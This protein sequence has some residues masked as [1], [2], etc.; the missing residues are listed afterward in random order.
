MI[1]A[2]VGSIS[3]AIIAAGGFGAIIYAFGKKIL[4]LLYD[5]IKEKLNADIENSQSEFNNMLEQKLKL[6]ESQLER[7]SHAARTRYDVETKAYEEIS[8]R[9]AACTRSVRDMCNISLMEN[10]IAQSE[11]MQILRSQILIDLDSLEKAYQEVASFI[12]GEICDTLDTYICCVNDLEAIYRNNIFGVQQG[13]DADMQR[14]KKLKS[15]IDSKK[16]LIQCSIRSRLDHFEK[17]P[18]EPQK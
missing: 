16:R 3:G 2:F 14:A 18:E 13:T 8:K 6:L 7:S 11:K 9:L 4:S 15:E 10:E 17:M 5:A 1:E 12:D